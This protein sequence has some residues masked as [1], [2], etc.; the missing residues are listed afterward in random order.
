MKTKIL[1]AEDDPLQRQMIAKLIEKQPGLEAVQ[2]SDGRVALSILEECAPE[3]IRLVIMDVNMPVMGGLEALE[4]MRRKYPRLPVLML[5]SSHDTGHVVQAMKQGAHDFLNKPPEPERLKVSI[6]NALRVSAL[7]KEVTRLKKHEDGA[8]SFANLIGCDSGLS[9]VVKVARKAA[10]SDIPVLI[11][12]E[13]GVG[14]EVL[15]RAIHGQSGRTGK[16]FIAVNCGAIPENLVESTLFGHEKGAFTGAIARAV[17]RFREAEG[18]TIFLDE[19]GELPLD[20]QVK[21][22]RALQQKEVVPVGAAKPVHIDARI[23]SATNRNL[24]AEVAAGRFRGDLYFRLNVLQIRMPSLRDRRRDIPALV[25]HFIERCAAADSRPL[26]AVSPEALDA[27]SAADWPGNIRELENTIQ[28][29]ML[30]SEGKMLEPADF[31]VSRLSAATLQDNAMSAQAGILRLTDD[32]GELK[33]LAE[34]EREAIAFSLVHTNNNITRAAN[35]LGMS[36]STFYRKL[37][38]Q[39]Q[40]AER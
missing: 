7:E 18:G 32:K 5:T 23:I 2:A 14:K 1:L 22:L 38:E 6:A 15:A 24:E 27:L 25:Q 8:Y 19:I 29:A 11:T 16:P 20:A 30:L 35:A 13:T 33:S 26:K 37:E 9:D 17:G 31:Q 12:G 34:I 40:K 36:K 4:V 28:R 21:L 10:Q 39:R 3:E